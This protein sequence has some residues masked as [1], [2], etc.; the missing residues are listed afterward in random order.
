M[1]PDERQR[2]G[3]S[4]PRRETLVRA[5]SILVAGGVLALLAADPSIA[6]SMG[7]IGQR[8]AGAALLVGAVL[9]AARGFGVRGRRRQIRILTR[10][11]VCWTLA[12]AGLCAQVLF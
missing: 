1:S 8:A 7:S 11:A 6:G 2:T 4:A 5:V 9:A 3:P 10:P 12:A